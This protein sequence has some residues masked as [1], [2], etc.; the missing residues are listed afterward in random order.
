M[1]N[2]KANN[3]RTLIFVICALSATAAA[4][5]A[6]GT[7]P[8]LW[9]VLCLGIAITLAG[10]G[11]LL[12]RRADALKEKLEQTRRDYKRLF[13]AVPCYICVLDE[14][15]NILEANTLYQQDFDSNRGTHCYEVCKGR[16]RA[17]PDCL[18]A[19][20]FE[21][22]QVHS[23]EE[24]LNTRDGRALD[25][26]VYSMPVLNDKGQINAVMEVFTD[27]TEVKR[28][29]RQLTLMGRAVAGMAHRIKNILMGLEGGI[30]VVNTGMES[31]DNATIEEG[32]EMVERNVSKVSRLV[33]DLLFCSKARQPIFKDN[34]CPQDIAREVHALFAERSGADIE[35]H[36]DLDQEPQCGTFDPDGLANLLSNLMANAIDACRFNDQKSTH[37][38]TLR[39]R[40]DPQGTCVFEIEDDGP[41]IPDDVSEKMFEDFFSTK[42][43]EGTGIG[44][45][46]VRKVAN[47][48]GGKVSFESELGRGT[49]FRVTLPAV[50]NTSTQQE[51]P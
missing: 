25:M 42:G 21:D 39:C 11:L 4:A 9:L 33:K 10:L 28:L 30:F 50:P 19:Q 48:H 44:L 31:N 45:L 14:Q 24:R 46:V 18:V 5:T 6:I 27:I 8:A 38:I 17:C 12:P 32:W 7:L 35:L 15:L 20:T 40:Q 51:N 22:G 49:T 41:G 13:E 1:G 37:H 34:V 43:T 26:V 29:Q 16:D 3:G 23:S 47:E 2:S 36:L